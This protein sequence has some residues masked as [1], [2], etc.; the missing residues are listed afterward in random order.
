MNGGKIQTTQESIDVYDSSSNVA[1]EIN[2]GEII[3]TADSPLNLR[4]SS[5]VVAEIN[6]G[7]LTSGPNAVWLYMLAAIR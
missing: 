4:G 1:I 3:A 7:T 6:G 2:A 5:N